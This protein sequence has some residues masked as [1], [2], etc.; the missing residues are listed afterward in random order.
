MF[1]VYRSFVGRALD[2]SRFA[3][4]LRIVET[5]EK[6]T[7]RCLLRLLGILIGVGICKCLYVHSTAQQFGIL[8][9]VVGREL[10]VLIPLFLATFFLKKRFQLLS[11][12]ILAGFIATSACIL[13]NI[14]A[15]RYLSLTSSKT[16]IL[17]GA[18]YVERYL[19]QKSPGINRMIVSV[20]AGREASSSSQMS[21]QLLSAAVPWD[22]S[23]NISLG[24]QFKFK[25]KLIFVADHD[26][27]VR[28][29]KWPILSDRPLAVGVVERT[30]QISITSHH[31]LTRRFARQYASRLGGQMVLAAT[32]GQRQFLQLEQKLQFTKY[33]LSHLLV[34][35]GY[36]LA[37]VVTLVLGLG[38][39]FGRESFHRYRV[40]LIQ[41]AFILLL[42]LSKTTLPQA[43][44]ILRALI[45]M[46]VLV[47]G[48]K[49][50]VKIRFFQLLIWSWIILFVTDY[51]QSFSASALYTYSAMTAIGLWLK[52]FGRFREELT[53]WKLR[54]Y[55]YL[56]FV[57]AVTS[58]TNLITYI[59]YGQWYFLAY[60]GNIFIAP[61]LGTTLVVTGVIV[62]LAF[63]L[64]GECLIVEL[65][66]LFIEAVLKLIG[67][68]L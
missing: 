5:N 19:G 47:L 13:A 20:D 44:P 7:L 48:E 53:P 37:V 17:T 62:V 15:Q 41:M 55:G 34:I 33:G 36:H 29:Y 1:F 66:I 32:L 65:G 42:I 14:D 52:F 68:V 23:E 54:F 11:L 40:S 25:T 4:Y 67:E 64:L 46:G 8:Q 27:I 38:K 6:D 50:A 56:S 35:S 2:T 9:P 45:F 59:L 30:Q 3:Q 10:E 63:A 58:A 28:S 57:F 26:S 12:S 61:F 24:E 51:S 60:I 18:G 31:N 16:P 22:I 21:M 43:V 39:I 49:W